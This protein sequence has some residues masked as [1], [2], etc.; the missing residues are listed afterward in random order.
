MPKSEKEKLE[1]K[2]ASRS[3]DIGQVVK[4][5]R[6]EKGLSGVELCRRSNPDYHH[7]KENKS[8]DRSQGKPNSPFENAK[9]KGASPVNLL[10]KANRSQGKGIE[11]KTLTALEKGRI[12]NPSIAS[13]EALAQG[14]GMTVSDLFRQA[15]FDRRDYFSLGSQKGLYKI[16]LPVPGIQLISFT[17]LLEQFFCGKMILEGQKRFDEKLF[18]SQGAFFI[19]TLIGQVEGELEGRKVTLKEGDNLYFYGGMKFHIVNGL[20]RHSTL[21]LVSAPSL[22]KVQGTFR[23]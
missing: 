15:E 4:R 22:L 18:S 10:G 16:D 21:L 19:M 13:L 6:E 23:S 14:L 20:Q 9:V 7:G 11:P 12:R 8:Q 1:G 3:L 17:P 2:K 5:L